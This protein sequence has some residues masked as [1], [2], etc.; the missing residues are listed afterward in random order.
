MV[1]TLTWTVQ[2]WLVVVRKVTDPAVLVAA[3][4][5]VPVPYV[6]DAVEPAAT[7]LVDFV[8]VI[9]FVT[10]NDDAADPTVRVIVR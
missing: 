4:E 5:K 9:C 2:T 3:I 8:Y 7:V 6:R 1:T 10:D